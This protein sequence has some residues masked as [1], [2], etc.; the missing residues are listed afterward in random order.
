MLG[1]KLQVNQA[2]DKQCSEEELRFSLLADAHPE[3]APGAFEFFLKVL[4]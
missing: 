4:I 3:D 2:D 1:G